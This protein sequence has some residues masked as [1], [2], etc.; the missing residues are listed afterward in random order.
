ML[1]VVCSAEL[2]GLGGAAYRSGIGNGGVLNFGHVFPEGRR[3][4][5][6]SGIDQA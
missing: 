2:G 5:T 1:Y 3:Q 4:R 6:V